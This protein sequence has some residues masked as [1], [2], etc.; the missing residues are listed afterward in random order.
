[1]QL[2]S[3]RSR[4]SWGI[5]DLG[6]LARLGDAAARRGAEFVLLNP[7]HAVAPIAEQQPSPYFPT[8]RI[9]KNPI[10][11]S[12]PDV[13]TGAGRR[14]ETVG[15]SLN[16]G[17]RVDRDAVFALKMKALRALWSET[18]TDAA[19]D[20]FVHASGQPLERYAVYCALAERLG[21][22]WT[23]WP[24]SVRSPESDDVRRFLLRERD[25]VRFHMWLQWLIDE[26]LKRAADSIG[27]IHDVAIGVDPR[28]ADVWQ[29]NDVFAEGVRI[30]APPDDYNSEG[31]DWGV[32]AFDPVALRRAEMEPFRMMVRWN[33]R[34]AAGLR[35]DH[36]M[37][38][39][40]LFWIPEGMDARNGAYVR[41]PAT[42]QLDVLAQESQ[43]AR[44][45]VI[46]EDLGTVEPSVRTEMALRDMLSYRLLWFQDD[47]V[48]ELP[49]L[50]MASAN[51]HDLP[52]T[53]GLWTGQ[54]LKAQAE[55]GLQPNH[56]FARQMTD[57]IERHLQ[58]ARTTSVRGVID[59]AN[60]LLGRSASALVTVAIEDVIEMLE[61][62]NMPGTVS[63]LNWTAA[64]PVP[65]EDVIEHERFDELSRLLSESR[66]HSA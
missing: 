11:I 28:G 52:T 12:V 64:L 26:Q 34:H 32:T 48:A 8:S 44:A 53:A 60:S 33:L 24:E 4:D 59:A 38:M 37:G 5:G 58:T 18:R 54:D 49:Y 20:E 63:E 41:Y 7:L 36:V 62:Y 21:A 46:G 61:R 30:G 43:A 10:Y 29:Y 65:L 31:Q 39:F 57:R 27:L 55:A 2:Y 25:Q 50:A 3:L 56:P 40:R 16:D 17:R 13:A 15:S 42:E 23:A 1:M 66:T 51:T 19:F 22:D 6:D 14:W 45:F 9:F 35:F 47:D